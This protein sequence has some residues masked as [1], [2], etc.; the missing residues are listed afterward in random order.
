[1]IWYRFVVLITIVTQGSCFISFF[2]HSTLPSL[3]LKIIPNTLYQ[4]DDAALQALHVGAPVGALHGVVSG[5]E[6]AH[7]ADSVDAAL[8]V[9][10]LETGA[11]QTVEVLYDDALD[12]IELEVV[13]VE[14][15]E[16]VSRGEL[17]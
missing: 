6:A 3:I 13:L 12:I 2:L 17:R 16:E 10:T 15:E 4:P 8:S 11:L 7:G 14:P 5:V 9:E 1:M